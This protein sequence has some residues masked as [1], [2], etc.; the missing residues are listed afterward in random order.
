MGY[1]SNWALAELED[2]FSKYIREYNRLHDEC[3]K[4]QVDLDAISAENDRL[5]S[6]VEFYKAIEHGHRCEISHC[7]KLLA[8]ERAKKKPTHQRI[9]EWLSTPIWNF[10]G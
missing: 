8:E 4:K 6:M 7:R 3:R 1:G 10:R 2:L 9:I 5:R